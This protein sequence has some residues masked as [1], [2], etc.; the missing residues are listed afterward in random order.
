[1][2]VSVPGFPAPISSC[3]SSIGFASTSVA[4]GSANE[5]FP[6]PMLAQPEAQVATSIAGLGEEEQL[7]ATMPSPMEA[8]EQL[9]DLLAGLFD[10][11]Q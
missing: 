6:S 8:P 11:G 10:S 7:L 4:P 3:D 9:V 1:V 5:A 2:P